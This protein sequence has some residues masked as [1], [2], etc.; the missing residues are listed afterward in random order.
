MKEWMSRIGV[1]PP[2]EF[3]SEALAYL[4]KAF[5]EARLD[6]ETVRQLR[7]HLVSQWRLGQNGAK[8]AAATCSCDGSRIVPSPASQIELPRRA[9]LAPKGAQR[10]DVFGI[11]D[12]REPG[13]LP[14]IRVQAEIAQ[15]Q[16][17]HYKTELDALQAQT[18]SEGMGKASKKISGLVERTNREMRK[19]ATKA[20]ELRGQVD[21]LAASAPWTQ[22]E[23]AR[24]SAP[25]SRR[26]AA[27]KRARASAPIEAPA[28]AA[29]PSQAAKKKPCKDCAPKPASPPESPLHSDAALDDLVREFAE[30]A[31]QDLEGE[32]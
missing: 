20:N 24:A 27:R 10:G 5:P 21:T 16:Y 25:V 8:A 26:A 12:L 22:S 13:A 6:R 17:E 7:P 19:W 31:T 18:A 9:A 11:E 15:R 30:G 14:R 3:F 29:P 32:R 1:E 4:N 28:A 2:V 23:E